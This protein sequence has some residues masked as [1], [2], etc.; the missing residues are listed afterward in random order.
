MSQVPT[1][2]TMSVT[3]IN[4]VVNLAV[5]EGNVTKLVATV[6]GVAVKATEP[7]PKGT[8]RLS[9]PKTGTKLPVTI[10]AAK[11]PEPKLTVTADEVFKFAITKNL[12]I[13]TNESLC[14]FLNK[15]SKGTMEKGFQ[16]K[17]S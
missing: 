15:K 11:E 8:R 3:K 4:N 10:G 13:D 5:V 2:S 7:S 12:P 1:A 16:E 9:L 14:T 6:A 17:A